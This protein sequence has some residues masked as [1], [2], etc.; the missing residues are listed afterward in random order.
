MANSAFSK[1]QIATPVTHENGGLEAD[2]SA[3]SGLVKISGG[4]TSQAVANTDYAPPAS[5]TFTGVLTYVQAEAEQIDLGNLGTSE[6]I[7]W[8]TAR[9]FTGTLDQASCTFTFTNATA[10]KT[11]RLR[12]TGS[13][14]TSSI[15]L[16]GTVTYFPNAASAAPAVPGDGEVLSMEIYCT[17]TGTYD[18]TVAATY[19]AYS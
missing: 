10:G 19:A 9:V 17:G 2:V 3:Y 18:V 12:L 4:V 15:T 16:P 8:N 13:A 14:S 5:P 11:I 1:A 7:D 6:T